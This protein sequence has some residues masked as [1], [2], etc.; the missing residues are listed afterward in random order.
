MLLS[1]IGATT[2]GSDEGWGRGRRPVIYV[3]R[4]DAKL[5][6]SWLSIKTGKTYRL[7]TEAEWEYA[8]RA[9]TQS[10]FSFGDDEKQLEG[11]AWHS[12]N[13]RN[14]TQIV[15]KMPANSFG[16]YDMLGN[17]WEWCEDNWHENYHGAPVDG[18]AWLLGGIDDVGVIR[19]GGWL[20][21]LPRSAIRG[22][23]PSDCQYRH[24]GFRVARTLA[25]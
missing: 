9:G 2:T 7:L 20:T 11:F 19:G 25:P 16:L 18:S 10:R 24:L 15:G 5:Y 6:I 14:R 13:S 12:H 8:A 22:G 3:S 4:D 17:V 21:P 1:L 23:N